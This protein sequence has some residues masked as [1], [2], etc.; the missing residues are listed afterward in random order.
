M[1]QASSYRV[2]ASVDEAT[3]LLAEHGAAARLLAGGQTLIS[4]LWRA[5]AAPP[6]LI[7][8]RK[9]APLHGIERGRDA[10]V[11]GAMVT[12]AEAAEDAALAAELPEFQRAMAMVASLPVRHRAT[13]GG[14]L[15]L[16]E[17][18]SELLTCLVAMDGQVT[19]A[20]AA[21]ARVLSAGEFLLGPRRTACRADELVTHLHLPRVEP[22]E[23][24]AFI[25]IT[26]RV[27]GGRA[28]ALAFARRVPANGQAAVVSLTLAGEIGAPAKKQLGCDLEGLGQFSRE[29][30]GALFGLDGASGPSRKLAE[31]AGGRALA[32]LAAEEVP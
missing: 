1:D 4:E 5:S 9:V 29:R 11:L 25:E 17:P 8:L 22:G 20:S 26:R 16:A 31:A 15:A 27:S 7:D 18:T 23:A 28:Q 2:P 32:Q 13:I 30:I 12:I 19:L 3:A 14:T 21:G 24:H 6:I 10:I